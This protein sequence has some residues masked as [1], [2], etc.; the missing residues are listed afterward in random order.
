MERERDSVSDGG[1]ERERGNRGNNNGGKE[2]ICVYCN[3][4]LEWK[5]DRMRREEKRNGSGWSDGAEKRRD[6]VSISE[7]EG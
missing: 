4:S 1:D 2:L 7:M 3:V 5:S 6:E